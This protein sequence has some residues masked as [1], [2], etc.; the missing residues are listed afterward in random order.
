MSGNVETFTF[1]LAGLFCSSVKPFY[2]TRYMQVS[3]YAELNAAR[4]CSN[5][6]NWQMVMNKSTRQLTITLVNSKS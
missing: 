2:A 4:L 3:F 1:S 6:E 5:Q